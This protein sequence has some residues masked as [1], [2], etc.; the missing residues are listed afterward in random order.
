MPIKKF[1]NKNYTENS[2]IYQLKLPLEL[3]GL[4][5]EDDSV[6]LLSQILEELNYTKL[7]QAYS[8]K[9]RNPVVDP[10]TMFKI[11]IYAYSQNIYSTHKIEA[12]CKRDINFMWLLAGQKAPDHSTIARFRQKYVSDAVED[13]FYQIVN[14]LHELKEIEYENVF[15]DGTKIEANANRYTFVWKKA[16]MKNEEKMHIK[17]QEIINTINLEY[18]QDFKFTPYTAI[19][20]IEKVTVFLKQKCTDDGIVF[21]YGKGKRPKPLQKMYE[22]MAQ[23]LER[24]KIY[25]DNKNKFSGRNSFSKTDIDA[26]FMHMKEDHMR[27]GQL[28]PGYNIQIGVEAEY[29]TGVGVFSDRNDLGTL[30]PMLKSMKELSGHKYKNVTADSGYESEEN[31]VY[32]AKEKQI[33]FIKPQTYEK[34]KKTS[35][36]NDIS[37]RENMQYDKDCDEYIC[38]NGKRLKPTYIT[39]KKSATG[40]QSEVTMYECEDCSECSCKNKCTKAQ[41]NRKMQVS[42]L[43]VE[44]REI[45]YQNI[46]SPEGTLLRM[47]RS[48]QVE[49]AFGVLKNDYNFKRFLTRGKSSVKTEFLFLCMGYNINKLHSKIQNDR[50]KMQLHPLKETA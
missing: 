41:G 33:A 27:N 30:I 4:I 17:V 19:T 13:L 36:K 10:K 8:A 1:T 24:Q 48:I 34:W 42:K 18:T 35:F 32:L 28:K 31:Y 11:L 29:I 49:G 25:D 43:F 47:N 2:Q 50:L 45:S 3:S 20:D 21:V 6:R 15:I 26:T 14:L 7:H 39:H 5:P 38:H 46:L 23:Y 22:T 12:A 37:K 44:K 40:Y 16:V 9:G